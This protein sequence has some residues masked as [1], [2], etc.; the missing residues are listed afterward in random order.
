ML[1]YVMPLQK[2]D[3]AMAPPALPLPTPLVGFTDIQV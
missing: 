1:N 2:S 3:R